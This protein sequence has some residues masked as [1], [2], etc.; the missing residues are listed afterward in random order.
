MNKTVDLKRVSG[1]NSD[2]AKRAGVAYKFLESIGY[3]VPATE[4]RTVNGINYLYMQKEP[5]MFDLGTLLQID[6]NMKLFDAIDCIVDEQRTYF[7][8]YLSQLIAAY[9]VN[10][11]IPDPRKITYWMTAGLSCV[12]YG[13]C[14]LEMPLSQDNLYFQHTIDFHEIMSEI[15]TKY[16]LSIKIITNLIF[17]MQDKYDAGL[18]Y[19]TSLEYVYSNDL[20]EY[21]DI[22]T[23]NTD[24]LVEWLLN[25][26]MISDAFGQLLRGWQSNLY[27]TWVDLT[28]MG[29]YTDYYDVEARKRILTALCVPLKI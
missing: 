16:P 1:L 2:S 25:D 27:D 24:D 19:L 22:I 4:V 10:A 26:Y 28:R 7:D 23:R 15:T 14:D 20:K 9:T 3:E 5:L 13:L 18:K 17:D 12:Y 6:P 21:R 11:R 8:R 29:N